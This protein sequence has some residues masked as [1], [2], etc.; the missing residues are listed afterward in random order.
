MFSEYHTINALQEHIG[1]T[2]FVLCSILLCAAHIAIMSYKRLP[3]LLLRF[4]Q[5]PLHDISA[6]YKLYK[7]FKLSQC[8]LIFESQ[9][10]S[11]LGLNGAGKTTLINRLLQLGECGLLYSDPNHVIK[12]SEIG[13]CAQFNIFFDYLT[14]KQ[15]FQLLSAFK[16]HNGCSEEAFKIAEIDFKKYAN[17]LP[18]KLSGGEQR[19]LCIS[20]AMLGSNK[21]IIFDEPTNSIDT[22]TR[23]LILCNI[24]QYA[25]KLK[26]KII[27]TTN[28]AD[29]IS[30]LCEQIICVSDGNC[31]KSKTE[32]Q[33][34]NEYNKG[35]KIFLKINDSQAFNAIFPE[36]EGK[37]HNRSRQLA[38]L[39]PNN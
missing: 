33:F 1:V 15:H 17:E 30:G 38:Q 32:S 6:L 36:F 5:Q 34:I 35:Y 27:I 21:L 25:L 16:H 26:S 12:Q 29:E 19:K 7:D 9:F 4:K 20:F 14:V 10:Y 24:K 18:T 2:K 8:K 31:D 3:Q 11:I 28:H 23:A 39:N 22:Q 13:I 37:I